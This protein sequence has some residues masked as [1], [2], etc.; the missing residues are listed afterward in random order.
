MAAKAPSQQNTPPHLFPVLPAHLLSPPHTPASATPPPTLRQPLALV[1]WIWNLGLSGAE[2]WI[3]H[4]LD[5]DDPAFH[6]Q[7]GRADGGPGGVR[8]AHELVLDGADGGELLVARAGEARAL[9]DVEGVDHHHVGE[10]QALGG[11]AQLDVVE[12][13]A[14]ARLE[15]LDVAALVGGVITD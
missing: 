7:A 9:P 2:I 10:G 1:P 14:D 11:E 6:E 4:R 8:G 13:A 5:L 3:Y 15:A 12:G